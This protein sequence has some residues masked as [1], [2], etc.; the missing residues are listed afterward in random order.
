VTAAVVAGT[1]GALAVI[2]VE[3]GPTG[4]SG[5]FT[6]V[7]LARNVTVAGTVATPGL[8]ELTFT[9]KPPAG[10]GA[11]SNRKSCCVPVGLAVSVL[12]EN[13]IVSAASTVW[14]TGA[15]P[16]ADAVMTA[17]P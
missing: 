13:T 8:L 5:T 4:V 16:V 3:P 15:Y 1:V 10:A 2:V 6:F 11:V 17:D 14:L 7:V 12:G 9:V